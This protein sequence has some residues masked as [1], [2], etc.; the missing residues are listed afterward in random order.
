M[1]LT[2]TY[3]MSMDSKG[4]LTL[5]ADFRKELGDKVC[6]LPFQG[7]VLGF[8]PEGHQAYVNSYFEGEG[9]RFNPR[10]RDDVKVQGY[11]TNFAKTVEL[12][13]AGRV[14]LGKLESPH[15][16]LDKLGLA[17]TVYVTGSGDHFE[18]WNVER[19]EA[20]FGQVEEDLDSLIF[21]A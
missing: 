7:R 12:D 6:L 11:L 5:P 1:Y 4:R 18:I 16:V 19:W 10:N 3:A 17:G 15:P 13:K 14:A 8:T 20:E 2:G 21:G 9:R